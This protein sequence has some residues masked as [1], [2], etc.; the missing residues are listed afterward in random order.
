MKIKWQFE[1]VKVRNSGEIIMWWCGIFGDK[2]RFYN[3]YP[4]IKEGY[5]VTFEDW[6]LPMKFD[7]IEIGWF[8]SLKKS[9]LA[10]EKHLINR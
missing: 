7:Q 10:C 5:L 4:Y 2:N 1:D 9:K 6:N 8:D 3:I